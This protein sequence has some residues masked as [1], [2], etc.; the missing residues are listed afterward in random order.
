[1]PSTEWP[2]YSPILN[3]MDYSIWSILEARTCAKRHK[4][5]KALKESLRREWN[6]I[7]MTELRR[8]S[9]NFTTRLKLCI[10]T[11]QV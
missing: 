7:L 8:V 10:T 4:S 11:D 5:L 3:P 1:M 6:K 2:P 9:E